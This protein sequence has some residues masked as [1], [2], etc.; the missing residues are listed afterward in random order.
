MGKVLDPFSVTLA[1]GLACMATGR[2]CIL[3][4]TDETCISY[5]KPRALRFAKSTL[6]Q[7]AQEIKQF[8]I[9]SDAHNGSSAGRPVTESRHYRKEGDF[10]PRRAE[11]LEEA[12]DGRSG[13]VTPEP[14]CDSNTTTEE[15]H[16]PSV[17]RTSRSSTANSERT[18]SLYSPSISRTCKQLSFVTSQNKYDEETIASNPT[19]AI[20]CTLS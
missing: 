20:M 14:E 4:E 19:P 3:L 12:K 7:Q 17:S 2:R 6:I 15:R 16:T 18:A 8:A 1:P 11:E 10:E 9:Q 13:S 5:A